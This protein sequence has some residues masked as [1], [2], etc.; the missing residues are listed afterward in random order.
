MN[1]A[2]TAEILKAFNKLETTLFT[3]FDTIDER[4]NALSLDFTSF[5]SKHEIQEQQ[6]QSYGEK[7]KSNCG[8]VAH[9]QREVD[10]LK[11]RAEL[12]AEAA[13]AQA[14]IITD[15]QSKQRELEQTVAGLTGKIVG[16]SASAGVGVTII[17]ALGQA[18]FTN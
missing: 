16:W 1:D 3:K 12:K 7:V 18:F 10:Q 9:M 4:I 2:A 14:Q 13:V 17:L 6:F 15:L 8:A 5:L 11:I